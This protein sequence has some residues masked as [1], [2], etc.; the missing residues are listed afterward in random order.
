MQRSCLVLN[1]AFTNWTYEKHVGKQT[2]SHGYPVIKIIEIIYNYVHNLM[3]SY[4]KEEPPLM[5]YIC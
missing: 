5:A 1:K 2:A 4:M 3:K